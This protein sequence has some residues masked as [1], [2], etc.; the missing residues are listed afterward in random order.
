[1]KNVQELKEETVHDFASLRSMMAILRGE[2]GCPWDREQTH[3]SIRKCLIEETY[4]VVEAIDTKNT[5]L[6]REELGDLLFQVMFHARIEEEK[7]T[8]TIDDVIQDITEKMIHRHPHVFEAEEAADSEAVL[9]NW[10]EIKSEEKQ[11]ESVSQALRRVPPFLPA[12]M[13]AQK[14]QGKARKKISVGYGSKEEALAAGAECLE[15]AVQKEDIGTLLA[16][17]VFALC[18]AAELEGIDLEAALSH[19]CDAF[20]ESIG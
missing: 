5:T 7:G 16:E 18:A 6:L 15:G 17:A 14:I 4:E 3:E 13:R 2:G 19:R 1:M 20:V 8:F 11:I 10:E 12:L 9:R